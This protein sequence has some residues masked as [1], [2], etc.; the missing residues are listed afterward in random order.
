VETYYQAKQGRYGLVSLTKRFGEAGMPDIELVDTPQG[1]R[2]KTMHNH[3]TAD[4][5][6]EIERKLGA[7]S[8]SSCSRTGAATRPWW[9]A[10]T[11][12]GYP[13]APTAP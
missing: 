4:L 5:L 9:P 12:A 10:R 1:P 8:R 13:S 3:F 2:G 6:G 11:A 7:K